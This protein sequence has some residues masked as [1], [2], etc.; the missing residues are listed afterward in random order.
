VTTLL[1]RDGVR[2]GGL[3][4]NEMGANV[5]FVDRSL[6]NYETFRYNGVRIVLGEELQEGGPTGFGFLDA[7][8]P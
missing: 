8:K 2:F 4:R 5:Y 1:P 6:P 3:Y 7:A